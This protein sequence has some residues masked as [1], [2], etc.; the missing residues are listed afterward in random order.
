MVYYPA[1]PVTGPV[2]S[3]V[4]NAEGEDL[5]I[6]PNTWVEIKGSNLAP[7]GDSR[8]WRSSDFTGAKMPTALDGVS[9]TVNGVSAY[10]YYISPTQINILTP[11]DALPAYPQIVVTNNGVAGAPSAAL[12]QT[13][14]PPLFVLSD[15]QHV[16]ANHLDGTPVGPPSLSVPGFTFTPAQ[17]G[18]TISVYANGFGPTSVAVVSGSMTQ[19]G[20]LSPL[21]MLTIGGQNAA[22]QY[23]GLVSPGLFYFNAIVPDS[24]SAGDHSIIA[25]YGGASTQPGTVL[26]VHP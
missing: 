10:V 19:G 26:S 16:A 7:A 21:P 22:V 6:A 18:E 9:A 4:A 20:V 1:A 17:P 5:T 13:L 24:L 12:G 3:L 25:T 8:I 2:V 23:A 14:A 11:P 15:D